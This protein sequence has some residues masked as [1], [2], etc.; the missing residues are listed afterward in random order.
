M[1]NRDPKLSTLLRSWPDVEPG[2]AFVPDALRRIRLDA[3]GRESEAASARAMR[4]RLLGA[5]LPMLWRPV[6]V[7]MAC[8]FTVGWLAGLGLAGR[9][10]GN[11]VPR[12]AMDRDFGLLRPGTIAGNY[13]VYSHA[14]RVP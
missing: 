9:G 10:T 13:V 8:A 14:G 3:A 1:E 12:A 11:P 2:T 5:W 7:T 4:A 6:A